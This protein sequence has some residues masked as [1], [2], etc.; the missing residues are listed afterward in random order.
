M[1]RVNPLGLARFPLVAVVVAFCGVVGSACS[2]A[3]ST[4]ST[5]PPHTATP[6]PTAPPPPPP[7]TSNEVT[8][9][10]ALRGEFPP[11]PELNVC[12]AKCAICHSTQYIAQQRLTAVQ[13][14]KTVKKM[15]GWGAPVDDDEAIVLARYFSVHFPVDLGDPQYTLVV[16]PPGA[17]P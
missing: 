1:N 16:P 11:G 7:P 9:A 5:T 10:M 4:T 13:W 6:P 15:K 8:R 2:D 14:E 12:A 3:P 17:L